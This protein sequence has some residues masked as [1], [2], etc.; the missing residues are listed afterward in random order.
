VTHLRDAVER[1]AVGPARTALLALLDAAGDDAAKARENIEN[2]Y[3]SAMDRV[4]GMYKRRAQ[5]SIIL[6]GLGVAIALNADTIYVVR[7]LANDATLR[8]SLV[9]AAQEYAKQPPSDTDS[10]PDDR[11]KANLKRIEGLG[12]PIGWSKAEDGDPA[13]KTPGLPFRDVGLGDWFKGWARLFYWHWLGW[14]L[15]A[16]AVSQGAPFW[17]DLL[18]KI[19]VIRST[20]KPHEKSPEEHSKE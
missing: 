17:F 4:S 15:T 5:W 20:V 10:K 1:A 18:N 8:A 11:L 14:L 9:T 16:A 3:N 7:A 12:L 19:I 6:L 13:R 2:W